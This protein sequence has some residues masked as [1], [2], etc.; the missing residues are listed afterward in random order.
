[1]VDS[2]AAVAFPA[3]ISVLLSFSFK[4]IANSNRQI[5][6]PCA[7][8]ANEFT[9]LISLIN[10]YLAFSFFHFSK[11]TLLQLGVYTYYQVVD[12][13]L[14]KGTGRYVAYIKIQF[15]NSIY[16]VESVQ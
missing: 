10:S 7:D 5:R 14:T 9:R 4:T 6:R 13:K 11:T 16:T 15:K 3:G 1:M 8:A 12:V 2:F